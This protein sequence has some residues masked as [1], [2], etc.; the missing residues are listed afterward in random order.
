[1]NEYTTYCETI[2]RK[3]S[4]RDGQTLNQQTIIKFPRIERFRYND[5]KFGDN[6]FNHKNTGVCN[7]KHSR[8]ELDGIL[9]E[10]TDYNY[11]FDDRFRF[12]ISA[13]SQVEKDQIDALYSR[14]TENGIIFVDNY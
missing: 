8:L 2:I 1:M 9:I 11:C 13:L 3:K 12:S 10:L 7:F 4:N 6:C 14:L 5:C